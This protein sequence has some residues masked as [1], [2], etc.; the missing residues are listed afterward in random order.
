METRVNN[1][2]IKCHRSTDCEHVE[3]T[4]TCTCM[5]TH[6]NTQLSV[7]RIEI[8]STNISQTLVNYILVQLFF[9]WF[10]DFDCIPFQDDSRG[11]WSRGNRSKRIEHKLPV[12]IALT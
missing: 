12:A 2:H 11:E 6:A 9:I 1:C 7:H 4:H 3:P 5:R 10:I 8:K